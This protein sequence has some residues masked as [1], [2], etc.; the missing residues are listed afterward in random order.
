MTSL[1]WLTW[2]QVLISCPLT[3][4]SRGLELVLETLDL[5]QEQ[6][7]L[8]LIVLGHETERS[9]LTGAVAWKESMVVYR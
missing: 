9:S 3:P 8:V 1:V 2:C 4:A 5:L 6:P 7:R